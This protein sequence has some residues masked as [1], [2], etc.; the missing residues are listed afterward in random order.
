VVVVVAVAL[1]QACCGL[2]PCCW[3][4]PAAA[5][6][7][8]LLA[9]ALGSALRPI[10]WRPALPLAQAFRERQEAIRA[11]KMKIFVRRG[12]PNYLAGLEMMRRLG[13]ELGIQVRSQD[14]VS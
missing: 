6:L 10:C 4:W 11:A 14:W 7:E 1:R 8:L 13:D 3:L 5:L 9:P 2:Q 12:G